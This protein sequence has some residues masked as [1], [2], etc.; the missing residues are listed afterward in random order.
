MRFI[1]KLCLLCLLLL[2]TSV[3]FALPQQSLVPGG[4]AVIKLDSSDSE[5]RFRFRGKPVLITRENNQYTA[6]V[7]LPLNLKPGEYYIEG[8][9]GEDAALQKKFFV[10]KDKKYT[11]QHI[12]IKDK[13]KV[14]PYAKD[15]DRILKEKKRKQKAR[16]HYSRQE[17]NLDFVMPVQGIKTGSFGK[18]RV[19]NG[20][21]RRPHSG[22]DI[23][24]D[25]GTPVQAPAAGTVIETGNFFFSGNLVYLDH[26]QGLITLFA[27]LDQVNVS[28]GNKVRKGQII[29]SVGA[30]GRVTGPHL[31]WSLGLNGTWV[32][33]A[34][35]FRTN[36]D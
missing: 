26:G 31:H 9:R 35:F 4:I 2:Q 15:M 10:V 32:D 36:P 11:T 17:V 12:T 33:P 18:R 27:H 25:T 22:M 13:R 29:G 34:L 20:Q 8:N 30:T 19:F 14:N 1:V 28:I 24:A 5:P 7:G 21:S 23:A 3:S 16:L 6:V